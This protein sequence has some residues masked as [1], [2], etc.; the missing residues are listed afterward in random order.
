MAQAKQ[1]TKAELLNSTGL[2][3]PVSYLVL[4]AVNIIV[5]SFAGR[6]APEAIV[7]GSFSASRGWALLHSMGTL[8]LLNVFM[9]PL[10]HYHEVVRGKMYNS[11]EWMLAYLLVNFVGLWVIARFADNLGLG[12][13]AWW[14]ALLLAIVLDWVQGL[15][16][17]ALSKLTAA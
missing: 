15:A 12:L 13:S 3:I 11:K 17:M 2:I 4:L 8:T 9:I 5:V 16:M 10:V 6:L 14:V 7:L 1:V